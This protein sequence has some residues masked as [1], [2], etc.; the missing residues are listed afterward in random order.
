[1]RIRLDNP[2]VLSIET[3]HQ[4]LLSYRDNQNYDAM[5]NLI[6]DL[7]KIDTCRQIVEF[8]AISFLYSFALNRRNMEGDRDRALQNS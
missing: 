6:D 2:D 3:V 4:Y 1:M 7:S 5:I 8:S